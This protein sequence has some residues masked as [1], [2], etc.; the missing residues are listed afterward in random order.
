[1]L[2]G[3]LGDFYICAKFD[4]IQYTALCAFDSREAVEEHV[5]SLSE[6]RMFLNTLELYGSSVPECVL[7]ETLLPELQEVSGKELWKIIETVG[8]G[9]V[10]V[11]P[12]S[13][14]LSTRRKVKTFELQPGYLSPSEY[15]EVRLREGAVAWRQTVRVDGATPTSQIS[16]AIYTSPTALRA[17]SAVTR[18]L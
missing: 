13:A 15:E 17:S 11:N 4:D 3:T 10:T 2:K 1:M 14:E 12:P 16:S 6:N 5:K 7:R 18:I 9:Y 8:V